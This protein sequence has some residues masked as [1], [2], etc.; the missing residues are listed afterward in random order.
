M[1]G[2]AGALGPYST[3]AP[4]GDGVHRMVAS[5]A[6]RG[7]DDAGTW[8]D[9]SQ[10]IQLGSR[11]LSILDLSAAGH[12]PM[13]SA[14]GRYVVT[15]N[16]EI[17]NHRDIRRR[18]DDAGHAPVWQGTSDTETLTAAFD[19]WGVERA[20]ADCV[21]MFAVGVWDRV[22]RT[23]TLVR[24]RIGEKPLYY[25]RFGNTWLFGSEL[26]ALATHPSFDGAI[27]P[28]A[29]AA[30]MSLGYVPAPASIY[31][32][33]RK[34]RPGT[35]VVLRAGDAAPQ[36]H[37]Y[38]SAV[39]VA[40]RPR[41]A[42]DR[43]EDAVDALE[44]LLTTA[45]EQQMI[46]DRPFGALL[47]GGIDSSTIVALMCARQATHL[48]TFSIGFRESAFNEAHHAAGVARHFGTVHTELYVGADDV[49]DTIPLLPRI[50]DEPFADVSQIP[51]YLVS[52]LASR[53]VTVALSGDGGD[54]LFGGYPRYSMGARLWP[55]VRRVPVGLRPLVEDAMKRVPAGVDRA[56]MWAFPND[57]VSGVRG[58]RPAQK[59][60]KLGRAFGSRDVEALYWQLLSPWAEPRLLRQRAT[61]SPFP[62]DVDALPPGSIEEMFMLRDLTG[63]LPDDILA[64]MDRASMAVSVESRAPLLDHRIVEFALQLPSSYKFRN[65][66][67]KWL[68]RQVLDRHVPKRLVDRPKMGFGIPIA[69]WLRG[70]LKGWAYD[71][72]ASC[73]GET[74]DLIDAPALRTMLDRHV[75]GV[76]DWHLPI[77]TAL[78]FLQ[79]SRDTASEPVAPAAA[80]RIRDYGIDT[81]LMAQTA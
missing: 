79:W 81:E 34:V 24:D 1:C 49:R 54:E 6:H 35:R 68:L 10:G 5:L 23:L 70:P 80:T 67:G 7:P 75:S 14:G 33:V 15:L 66:V 69:S 71:A 61:R 19:A 74:A 56:F 32:H 8:S 27:D 73:R 18:L 17:Y 42:F 72:I 39:D 36:E 9:P 53:T 59:L 64:K 31:R 30:Y 12:Q 58:L 50:W 29:L 76:G 25:G 37:A 45:V 77:W 41:L 78:M 26:K 63:Y 62:T 65:G 20:I 4:W 11:R 51:T 47:S 38:W 21:G 43:D 55:A 44:R 13:A 57:E 22:D 52:K 48:E 16:G 28:D 60:T 40:R 3:A 46:A 2:I